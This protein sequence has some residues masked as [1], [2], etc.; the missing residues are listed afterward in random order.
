MNIFVKE[1]RIIIPAADAMDRFGKKAKPG[2]MGQTMKEVIPGI[3]WDSLRH[4]WKV[5]ATPGNILH[6]NVI[7][8]VDLESPIGDYK[9]MMSAFPFKTEPRKHQREALETCGFREYFAYF[10]EPG[11]GKTKVA[12]DDMQIINRNNKVDDVL[13]T[14]PK[15]IIGTWLRELQTH[16]YWESWEICYWNNDV[17][18]PRMEVVYRPHPD[19]PITMR[20]FIV[21]ID[22]LQDGSAGWRAAYQFA[23]CTCN[24][25]M[26]VDE[27]TTIKNIESKRTN[28]A[29]IL[30]SHM[31]YRRIL[32]GTP[33]ANT[34]LDY[35]AQMSYLDPYIFHGWSFSAFKGH[36]AITGGYKQ[37]E[38][39]GYTNQDELAAIVSEHSIIKTKDECLDLPP[40]V[41]Q[42]REITLS[43]KSW[44]AYDAIVND[45]MVEFEQTIKS[46]TTITVDMVTKKIIKLRQ[47]TG[48][49][50]LA[51][52]DEN[53]NK[54]VIYVGD[55]KLTDLMGVMEECRSVKV[56]VWCQF[57]HEI[58]AVYEAME[59]AGFTPIKYY[60]KMT[61][62]ERIKAENR[63]ERG[64]AN[65]AVIQNDTGSM[66]LTLN[67]ASV[68]YIYSNPSYPLPRVQLEDRNYRD[69]QTK[70]VTIIDA[71]V[72][73]TVDEA[74]YHSLMDR[75]TFNSQISDA[76]KSKDFSTLKGVFYP[77]KLGQDWKAEKGKEER[78]Q[79]TER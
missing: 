65:V 46:G 14:C 41:Y 38:I 76:I 32:S 23:M 64:D 25:A 72:M 16:G 12:V 63:F 21:S 37:R 78:E 61:T 28:Q 58:H 52:T 60:G 33:I 56:I 15:S 1:G 43:K 73:G 49:W 79:T 68:A 39:Y 7:F 47:L 17:G 11:L 35:F 30:G 54:E 51:D 45:S 9:G 5:Y 27:S 26:L 20:W 53:K 36:Y 67:A 34:P 62:D 70:S 24:G 66:G 57:V 44:K 6:I 8:G 31:K 4:V 75:K 50:M 29:M 3:T 42:I 71:L 77:K 22:S 19:D 18:T 74:Q 48:G 69:G 10:M 2:M 59:K 55:E 40:R 13:V